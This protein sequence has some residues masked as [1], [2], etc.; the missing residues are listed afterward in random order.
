MKLGPLTVGRVLCVGWQPY[1]TLPTAKY[2]SMIFRKR[3]HPNMRHSTH[4]E[5]PFASVR[6]VR[7]SPRVD[8]TD[9]NERGSWT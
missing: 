7:N 4:K 3:L 8:L 2:P 6:P 9:S 1:F 5:R